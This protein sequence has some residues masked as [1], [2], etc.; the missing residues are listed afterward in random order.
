MPIMIEQIGGPDVVVAPD[1]SRQ[2][3][4]VTALTGSEGQYPAE[5]Q[6][7]ALAVSSATY[8]K[9]PTEQLA[10]LAHHLSFGA[11]LIARSDEGLPVLALDRGR[12][13]V[14]VT[15][16]DSRLVVETSGGL[17]M[18]GVEVDCQSE[19][20][21]SLFHGTEITRNPPSEAGYQDGTR[22]FW[23]YIPGRAVTSSDDRP[24]HRNISKGI[25]DYGGLI[26]IGEPAV[27]HVLTT[28]AK[29]E[30][31]GNEPDQNAFRDSSALLAMAGFKELGYD[32]PVSRS[33]PIRHAGRKAVSALLAGSADVSQ[34]HFER[35]G[36]HEGEG[37]DRIAERLVGITFYPADHKA[38]AKGV[39]SAMKAMHLKG[40]KILAAANGGNVKQY[41]DAQVS[42][43]MQHLLGVTPEV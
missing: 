20:S 18:L 26:A 6:F 8:N 17:S 33:E 36:G 30:L 24:N 10:A 3:K 41:V 1:R 13:Q 2:F 16:P 12:L 38:I 14:G 32:L 29:H 27:D 37:G 5:P 22:R 35:D 9:Q 21:W 31:K 7:A 19:V 15:A 39:I 28:L 42:A 40:P 25:Y 11:E 23:D 4:A 43:Y 34:I